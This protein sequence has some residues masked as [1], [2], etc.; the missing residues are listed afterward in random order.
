[1]RIPKIGR[2]IVTFHS[3]SS[4]KD[5]FWDFLR[6][7]PNWKGKI[8]NVNPIKNLFRA[9][10]F[11]ISIWSNFL[12]F[13][14]VSDLNFG[15]IFSRKFS[16]FQFLKFLTKK[17]FWHA[18]HS[19]DTN[20]LSSADKDPTVYFMVFNRGQ[21]CTLLFWPFKCRRVERLRYYLSHVLTHSLSYLCFS[22]YLVTS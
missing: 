22:W 20:P 4:E 10:I 17:S 3:Y 16:F 1:M 21:M 13:Q 9:A 12:K 7:Y 5:Y 8:L 14:S 19:K 6:I 11:A 2:I 15:K 18:C